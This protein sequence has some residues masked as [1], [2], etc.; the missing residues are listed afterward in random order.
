MKIINKEKIILYS[1][2]YNQITYENGEQILK[3]YNK[4][5][6]MWVTLRFKPHDFD[7]SDIIKL[8]KTTSK[9]A[10]INTIQY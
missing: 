7:D 4:K 6:N 5:Y 2:E 10:L 1:R 9:N 8:I 3:K